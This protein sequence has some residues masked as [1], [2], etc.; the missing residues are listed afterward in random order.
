MSR[1]ILVLLLCL[2]CRATASAG[3]AAA[4]EPAEPVAAPKPQPQPKSPPEANDKTIAASEPSPPDPSN[5]QVAT[6]FVSSK[7][8]RNSKFVASATSMFDALP[9]FAF[10]RG[11]LEPIHDLDY[12]LVT[13]SDP[14]SRLAGSVVVAHRL[15]PAELVGAVDRAFSAEGETVEWSERDGW[16]VGDPSSGDADIDTRVVVLTGEKFAAF[17]HPALLPRLDG[18]VDELRKFGRKKKLTSVQGDFDTSIYRGKTPPFP[19]PTRAAVSI[20]ASNRPTVR[21]DLSFETADAAELFATW[22]RDDLRRLIEGNLSLK[23]TLGQLH[24]KIALRRNKSAIDLE[25]QLDT[26]Q[27]EAMLMTIASTTA[28]ASGVGS[29]E[30]QR[31][32]E[33]RRAAWERR[34]NGKLPPSAG[35]P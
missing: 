4:A 23:M 9:D 3:P 12:V 18:W 27:A 7:L 21:T 31:R 15:D 34:N 6:V 28:R 5:P 25:L 35:V 33:A 2:G 19:P 22:F 16:K 30:L 24:D 14:S 29:D 10:Q 8:V 26:Q 17:I 32:A 13:T 20:N 11:G 1:R